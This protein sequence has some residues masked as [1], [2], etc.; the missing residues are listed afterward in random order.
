MSRL[1][2]MKYVKVDAKNYILHC[3]KS[4]ATFPSP[5]GMSLTKLS[6]GGKVANMCYGVFSITSC[7]IFYEQIF[8]YLFLHVSFS[9]EKLFFLRYSLKRFKNSLTNIKLDFFSIIFK[10]TPYHIR[11]FLQ[12]CLCKTVYCTVGQICS[13]YI[14]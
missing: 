5:A 7:S 6:L 3:K 9:T 13:G 8:Q 4:L 10:N 1:F 11:L 2:S 12:M 14:V